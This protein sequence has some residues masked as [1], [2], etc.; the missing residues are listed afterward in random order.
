MKEA[1]KL[2]QSVSTNTVIRC[3]RSTS[4][5]HSFKG[6][7][8]STENRSDTIG[9]SSEDWIDEMFKDICTPCRD[10]NCNKCKYIKGK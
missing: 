9:E 2:Y 1:G 5:N 8:I 4:G 10:K 3:D 6:T 7:V